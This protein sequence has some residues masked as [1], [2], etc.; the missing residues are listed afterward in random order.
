MNVGAVF[1]VGVVE[2]AGVDGLVGSDGT[3]GVDG[4]VGSD[5]MSPAGAALGSASSSRELMVPACAA[6]ASSNPASGSAFKNSSRSGSGAKSGRESNSG[7]TKASA[8][9]GDSSPRA[10]DE[11]GCALPGGVTRESSLL[12]G[13]LYHARSVGVP[14]PRRAGVGIRV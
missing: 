5:G 14:V 10:R 12:M 2:T 4:L 9:L 7:R 8:P 3:A 13:R 1:C 11:R 6:T